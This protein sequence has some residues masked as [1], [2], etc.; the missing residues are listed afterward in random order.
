MKHGCPA[1]QRV[2]TCDYQCNS[3]NIWSVAKWSWD[4]YLSNIQ[5]VKSGLSNSWAWM[6]HMLAMPK[7]CLVKGRKVPICHVMST[8]RHEFDTPELHV[9]LLLRSLYSKYWLSSV[10]PL[11]SFGFQLSLWPTARKHRNYN[12]EQLMYTMLLILKIT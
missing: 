9:P 1:V 3:Q 8:W 12:P 6:R 2:G 4:L 11:L 10:P 7:P 5:R